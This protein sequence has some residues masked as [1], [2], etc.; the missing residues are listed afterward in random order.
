MKRSFI[1]IEVSVHTFQRVAGVDSVH[2]FKNLGLCIFV[3]SAHTRE[4]LKRFNP[5]FYANKTPFYWKL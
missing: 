2:G 3:G 5:N 4:P 1:D